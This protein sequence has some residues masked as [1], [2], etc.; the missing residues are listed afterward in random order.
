MSKNYQELI[1]STR[2]RLNPESVSFQK[3]FSEELSSISYNDA[4]VYVRMAMKSVEPEYTKKT[5]EAGDKVKQHLNQGLHNAYFKYQGSVIT[6]THIKGYS[7]IDL[8]TISSRFY[9][10]DSSRVNEVLNTTNRYNYQEA[11][12][13]KLEKEVN[14]NSYTGNSLEDL[15]KLRI[16]SE[17]ILNSI[18]N[19]CETQHPKAIK[20]TNLSLKR[21]VDIVIANWYD[22][23]MS[24]INN[25]GDYRGVQIYDKEKNNVGL[26]DYPF[27]SINR[28]NDKSSMTNGRL[29]KMIRFLKNIKAAS[30]L[31]FDL[32]SFDI[33]AICY[34]ID[35]AKY[36]NLPFF[37][38]VSVLYSEI[39]TICIDSNYA[40]NIVSVDGREYIFRFS[41][42]KIVNLKKILTEIEPIH[43][44][45]SKSLIYG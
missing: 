37:E 42:E 28:I 15:R 6:N 18:Y 27:L 23:V 4:L 38:L 17:I 35:K 30:N 3:S 22:D 33:N 45:L 24:I 36:L 7:D 8:L 43:E 31:D 29:K 16:D 21:D 2:M 9:S 41:S 44:D 32:S 20:I 1:E 39:R 25:K 12:I 26:V 13:Q 34:N 11:S 14:L 5:K 19:I 10:W 40:D